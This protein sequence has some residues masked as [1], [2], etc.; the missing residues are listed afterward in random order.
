MDKTCL[1]FATSRSE[2]F[3]PG[4]AKCVKKGDM[5]YNIVDSSG[6]LAIFSLSN[7]RKMA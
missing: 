2:Y 6:Q 7:F 5:N 4:T 3:N 1:F